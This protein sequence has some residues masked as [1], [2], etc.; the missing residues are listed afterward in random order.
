MLS[1]RMVANKFAE[2]ISGSGGH[3]FSEGNTV[4]SYGYHFP[5]A[6]HTG[7]FTNNGQEIILF[8]SRGYSNTTARHKS[9]VMQALSDNSFYIIEIYNAENIQEG[10]KELETRAQEAMQKE[11]RARLTDYKNIHRETKEKC[12]RDIEILKQTLWV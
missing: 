8:N 2:G 10:I 3:M 7:K 5:I 6:R 9:H 11:K 1:N 12:L 4:Y